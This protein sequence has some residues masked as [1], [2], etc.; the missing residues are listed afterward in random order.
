M[1]GVHITS[2][3]HRESMSY[4]QEITIPHPMK[5]N[6]PPIY[7]IWCMIMKESPHC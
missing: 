3:T 7:I 4:V 1:Q 2:L 6:F 5:Y